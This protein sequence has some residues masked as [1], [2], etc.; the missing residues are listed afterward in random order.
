MS[1]RWWELK[2]RSLTSSGFTQDTWKVEW[3]GMG[4]ATGFNI[5]ESGKGLTKQGANIQLSKAKGKISSGEP[6]SV[7]GCICAPSVG[8]KFI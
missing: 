4:K 3:K 1:E 5:F 7:R 6:D 8:T 2:F